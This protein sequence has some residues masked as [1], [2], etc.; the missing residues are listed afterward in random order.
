MSPTLYFCIYKDNIH[1]EGTMSE[2]FDS[3]PSF[4]FMSKNGE[5]FVIFFN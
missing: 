4:Y 5:L 2:I 1:F 3:G